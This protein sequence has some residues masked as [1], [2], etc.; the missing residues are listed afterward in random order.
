MVIIVLVKLAIEQVQNR[1]LHHTLV[2]VRGS[3]LDDLYCYDLLCLEILTFH[4]LSKSALPKHIE[5]K[6]AVLMARLLGTKYVVYV[7]NIV[8]ILVIEPI[9]LRPL[10]WFR[11]YSSRIS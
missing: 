3:I 10:A 6:I 4:H 5:N 8:A 7:E 1:D 2:K 11:E 9:I